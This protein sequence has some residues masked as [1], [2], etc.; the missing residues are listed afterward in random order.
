MSR[1]G[2]LLGESHALVVGSAEL[3]SR[4]ER[5]ALGDAGWGLRGLCP[6]ERDGPG[7]HSDRSEQRRADFIVAALLGIAAVNALPTKRAFGYCAHVGMSLLIIVV[8][9]PPM[10]RLALA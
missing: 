5:D 1:N 7:L 3:L 4:L 10:V 8:L 6:P 2:S 9:V